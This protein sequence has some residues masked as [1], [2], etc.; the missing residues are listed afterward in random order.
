[1]TRKKQ[2]K[3]VALAKV[4]Q[5]AKPTGKQS[6]KPTG[7]P[8]RKPK[9]MGQP[10]RFVPEVRQT[11][12]QTLMAGATIRDACDMAG[13]GQ[14]TFYSW[15][16]IGDAVATGTVVEHMPVDAQTWP[17]YQEFMEQVKKAMSAQ[18]VSAVRTVIKAGQER[19][20]HH[21]TGTIRTSPPPSVTWYNMRGDLVFDDP[22]DEYDKDRN[23]SGWMREWS[24]DAWDYDGGSWQAQAWWLERR[25][26][27]EYGRSVQDL[28]LHLKENDLKKMSDEELE[29]IASGGAKRLKAGES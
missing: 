13:V 21:L 26:P 7:R 28:N 24:R 1:M 25:H 22:G 10:S 12:V 19:W 8:A 2:P 20:I 3:A 17:A 4:D 29:E 11:I 14:S 5:P 27:Q 6:G 18:R 9:P 15:M 23:P 16:E